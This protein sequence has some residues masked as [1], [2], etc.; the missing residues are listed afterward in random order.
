M[1]VHLVGIVGLAGLLILGGGDPASAQPAPPTDVDATKSMMDQLQQEYKETLGKWKQSGQNQLPVLQ[2]PFVTPDA[3]TTDL[4]T[5][6]VAHLTEA[7]ANLERDR[8]SQDAWLDNVFS[9][10]TCCAPL[11]ADIMDVH[12]AHVIASPHLVVLFDFDQYTLQERYQSRLDALLRQFDPSSDELLLIGRASQ[13]GSRA[14]NLILS[15]KRAGAIKDYAMDKF[16]LADEHIRYLFFGYDPPQLT[17]TLAARY[18]I[19]DDD[20]AVIDPDMN[21]SAGAKIN[22]SVVVIVNEG[23]DGVEKPETTSKVPK[24]PVDQ[25]DVAPKSPDSDGSIPVSM[26]PSV[27]ANAGPQPSPTKAPAAPAVTSSDQV[28]A[29]ATTDKPKLERGSESERSDDAMAAPRTAV[30]MVTGM[31]GSTPSLFGQEVALL[32]GHAGLDVTTAESDHSLDTVRRLL[33][34][35]TPTMGLV[36]SDVI[37][38]LNQAPEPGLNHTEALR[39]LFPLYN[40]DI[41]VFARQEVQQVKDLDGKRVIMGLKGSQSWVTAHHLLQMFKV[42]PAEMIDHLSPAESIAAV[43]AGQADAM[44]Y[45]ADKPFKL[46]ERIRDLQAN[47]Q[48]EPLVQA[49]HFVPLKPIAGQPDYEVST[50]GPDDYDWVKTTIPTLAVKIV[51]ASAHFNGEGSPKPCQKLTAFGR[52]I[53]DNL[54]NLKRSG[55]PK[56]QEVDLQQSLPSWTRDTCLQAAQRDPAQEGAAV[57]KR[58]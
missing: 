15:G 48:Y 55:H 28:S 16:A 9:C 53:R 24:P 13:I 20:I 19:S 38:Y 47:P 58:Q 50:I 52:V 42:Q 37:G 6:C 7:K 54:P 57:S 5:E 17:P 56:W 51:L 8:Y 1:L 36:S 30:V 29:A 41:H 49:V 11:L 31:S 4:P 32:A 2:S 33:T 35:E 3:L 23:D 40:A 43:L 12:V 22:Q 26:S 21:L 27:P 45:V 44:F 34:S 25:A 46:F 14:Y 10:E 39:L 18:G